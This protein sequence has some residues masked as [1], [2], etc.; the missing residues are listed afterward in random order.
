[1]AVLGIV[2]GII[3]GVVGFGASIMLLPALVWSFGPQD[4][5]PIMAIASLMANASRAA[6][7]WREIDW[8]VNA[9]YCAAAIPAAIVG[10]RTLLTLDA[11]MVEATLGT[12]LLLS[13]PGRR[14][15]LAQGFKMTLPG[16]AVVGAGIGFLTA[17][18]ASTGPINT[19]FFLAYGLTKGRFIA[20]E[21][22]G[23]AVI[24]ST[25]TAVFQM[26]GAMSA[27]TAGRGLAVGCALMIGSWLSKRILL[28]MDA[29]R[30]RFVIEAMMIAAG[31]AMI[32]GALLAAEAPRVAAQ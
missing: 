2:S 8:K 15:L 14:W 23:S 11:R 26:L 25:K 1:M 9:V 4:T 28:G 17:L 6:V 32:A 19:P 29:H 20:T 30:F 24:S 18:V 10:A 22:V 7:W 5:V 31:L 16:M 3:G 27:A 12:F 21:A 13:V